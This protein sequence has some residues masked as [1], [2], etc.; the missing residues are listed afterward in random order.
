MNIAQRLCASDILYSFSNIVIRQLHTK[1]YLPYG[2][3]ILP[4]WTH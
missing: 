3:V 1:K 4:H 2:L